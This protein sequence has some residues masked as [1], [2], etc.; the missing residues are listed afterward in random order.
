[1]EIASVLHDDERMLKLP[2]TCRIEAKVALQGEGKGHALGDV[3]KGASR[4][5]RVVQSHKLVERDGDELAKVLTYNTLVL[6][7]HRVLDGGVDD[8]L[9]GD[10][11]SHVVVDDLGVV[12]GPHTRQALALRLRDA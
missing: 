3:D 9:L 6:A 10:L 12:L 1:M 2:S 4:P 11:V 7:S 8:T 5:H